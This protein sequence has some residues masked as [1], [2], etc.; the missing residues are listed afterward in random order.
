MS[1]RRSRGEEGAPLHDDDQTAA[2]EQARDD[3]LT[4][5]DAWPILGDMLTEGER[6][7]STGRPGSRLPISA[8][9]AD[10][11]AQVSAWV[12]F[13]ARVL[14]DE[15]TVERYIGPPWAKPVVAESWAPP[16]LDTGEL[17]RHIAHHRIGHFLA[18]NPLE[19]GDFLDDAH[20]WAA[21]M[22]HVA[23]P[24]GGRWIRLHVP[25]PEHGTSALGERV[26]CGGEYRMWM[27]PGQD[28]LDDMVCSLDKEH[29]ITPA[30]WMA[31][32]RRRPASPTAA[33]GIVKLLRVA[34][35]AA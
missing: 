2:W 9:I 23:W 21:E 17:V 1:R 34:G 7:A 20:S 19:V 33:A 27:L 31:A 18:G 4:V 35:L 6:G 30:Q 13:L 24:S 12:V 28:T 5:A 16:T 32:I 10:V 22:R 26:A 15:V 11:R 29:R 25:C 3:L 14:M 8:H